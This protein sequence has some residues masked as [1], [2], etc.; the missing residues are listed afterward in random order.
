MPTRPGVVRAAPTL[1]SISW[2]R[3]PSASPSRCDDQATK[4]SH[5]HPTSDASWRTWS[6]AQSS[7]QRSSIRL[8]TL[9]WCN[10]FRPK[11]TRRQPNGPVLGGRTPH[12]RYRRPHQPAGARSTPRSRPT[13]QVL[14]VLTGRRLGDQPPSIAALTSIFREMP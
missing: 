11:D 10:I 14:T 8:L 13:L 9:L 6:S 1:T 7:R 2:I 12:E 5:L 3:L 4:V